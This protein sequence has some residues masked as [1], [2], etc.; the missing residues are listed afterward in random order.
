MLGAVCLGDGLGYGACHMLFEE[1]SVLLKYPFYM[2]Y[3][4]SI[5]YADIDRIYHTKCYSLI[6]IRYKKDGREHNI[7]FGSL[8]F[9]GKEFFLS[10]N[11]QKQ[12]GKHHIELSEYSKRN[13]SY[14][15]LS[16]AIRFWIFYGK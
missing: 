1:H 4:E 12:I 5:P 8:P 3:E 13:K 7:V 15:K 16:E 9:A 6:K 2:K 14:T 10:D 11:V